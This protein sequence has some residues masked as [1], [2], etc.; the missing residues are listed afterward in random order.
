MIEISNE[1]AI[2]CR[3]QQSTRQ[4]LPSAWTRSHVQKTCKVVA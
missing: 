3:V 1:M 4:Q 2:E